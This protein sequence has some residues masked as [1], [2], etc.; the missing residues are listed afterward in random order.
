MM[1]H[2]LIIISL[3]VVFTSC[4]DKTLELPQVGASGLTDIQNYSQV[5]VFYE[6]SETGVQANYNRKNTISTTHWI[7]NVDRKLP[8]SEVIPVLQQI[9]TKRSEKS[10][11]SAEGMGNYLSYSDVKDEKIALFSIDS[12]DYKVL[13][14]E[15]LA[16]WEQKD[17]CDYIFAFSENDIWLDNDKIAIG[18]WEAIR[19]DSLKKGKL[20]LHF[21][22]NISYQDYMTYRLSLNA[23]LPKEVKIENIELVIN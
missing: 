4:K 9:K 6:E 21:D 15:D 17:A 7:I 2:F 13:S 1:K 22:E 8:L 11:H 14:R 12:I 20:Q 23:N 10:L 5:W 3:F 16:Q 19:F 18:E